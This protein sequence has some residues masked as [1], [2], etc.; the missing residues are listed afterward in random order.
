[1]IISFFIAIYF[2]LRQTTN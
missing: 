2:Q 1:L